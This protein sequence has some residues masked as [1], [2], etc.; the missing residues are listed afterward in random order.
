MLNAKYWMLYAQCP[1][2]TANAH[3]DCKMLG[4]NYWA[5]RYTGSCFVVLCSMPNV[6]CKPNAQ[7]SMLHVQ[8]QIQCVRTHTYAIDIHTI[9]AQINIYAHAVYTYT[10]TYIYMYARAHTG[11]YIYIQTYTH[12][13]IYMHVRT[14]I[15]NRYAL[16][17]CIY[18]LCQ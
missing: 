1:D 18:K 7:C 5:N 4:L 13:Y 8:W 2:D 11:I 12:I 16:T 10:H 6:Q 15:C 3:Q 14:H 9:Y 17:L